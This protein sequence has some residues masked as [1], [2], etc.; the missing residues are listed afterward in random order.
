MP[1]YSTAAILLITAET[2]HCCIWRRGRLERIGSYRGDE[3]GLAEFDRLLPDLVDKPVFVTA[4]VIEE[5]FRNEPVVHVL[6]SDRRMVLERKLIQFFRTTGYR[7]ARVTGREEEGRRDDLVL[8][9]AL[10]NPEQLNLWIDRMLAAQIRLHGVLSLAYLMEL[11][12]R[13]LALDQLPCL[14]LVNFEEESGLRQTFLRSGSL[15][16]S[17]LLP[18]AA[19]KPAALAETIA[20]ECRQTRQYL[21]RLKLLPHDQVLDVRIHVPDPV[22]QSLH[23]QLTS[24]SLLRYQVHSAAMAAAELGI[25]PDLIGDRGATAVATIQGLNSGQIANIYAPPGVT[26]FHRLHRIRNAIIALTILMT[27]LAAAAGSMLIAEGHNLR[28]EQ[29]AQRSQAQGLRDRAR[30]L[31]DQMPTSPV[32]GEMLRVAVESMEHIKAHSTSPLEILNPISRA[33]VLCPDIRL[34]KIDWQLA[35]IGGDQ[36]ETPAPDGTTAMPDA[37]QADA[38]AVQTLLP[39]L[40]A[41]KVAVTVTLSGQVQP[42]GGYA[43]AQQAVLGFMAVLSQIQGMQVRPLALPTETKPE[44]TVR[45]TVDG[46]AVPASFS[47]QLTRAPRP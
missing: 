8:F 9:S 5:D 34:E 37:G 12:C 33:M 46:A 11:Y 17:R 44:A 6:G 16:F 42:T 35:G 23:G 32:P 18:S 30:F 19:I 13:H 25:D 10:T 24:T 31:R 3:E 41:G 27:G 26:R 7:S 47:I 45:A 39:S 38:G 40:V 14:L 15:R 22:A 28:M 43:E 29:A 1:S 2:L 36:A 4:D 20:N 21:E